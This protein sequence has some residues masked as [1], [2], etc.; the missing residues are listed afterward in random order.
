MNSHL[1]FPFLLGSSVEDRRTILCADIIVLTVKLG[2]IMD[3]K[4]DVQQ[5]TI[6]DLCRVKT[7]SNSFSVTSFAGFHL[8]ISRVKKD[9]AGVTTFHG[10][11]TDN[12]LKHCFGA[13]KTLSS[14]CCRNP[15]PGRTCRRKS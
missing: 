12:L 9:A 2:R 13:P 7:D 11:Y 5:F 1:S 15:L 8:L 3:D 6:T 4:A 10:L 14:D